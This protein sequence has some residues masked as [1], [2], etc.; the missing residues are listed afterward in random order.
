MEGE[1]ELEGEAGAR[2]KRKRWVRMGKGVEWKEG[3]RRIEK[4]SSENTLK[5]KTKP[6]SSF[7]RQNPSR[8]EKKKETK[9]KEKAPEGKKTPTKLITFF[10]FLSFIS[11]FSLYF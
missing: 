4:F 7:P 2:G 6:L 1:G 11:H 5:Q 8:H 10:F 3:G 9:K